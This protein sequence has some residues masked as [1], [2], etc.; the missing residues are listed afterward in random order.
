MGRILILSTS[1][2][3]VRRSSSS[4]AKHKHKR[5]HSSHHRKSTKKGITKK[6]SKYFIKKALKHKGSFR[7]YCQKKGHK[8]ANSACIR[9]ALHSRNAKTRKR[10]VFAHTLSKLRK[11]RK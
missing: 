3:G 6:N 7:K 2:H 5:A 1:K 8:G 11:H 10:A 9:A 4:G